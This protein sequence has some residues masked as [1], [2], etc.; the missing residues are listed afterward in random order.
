[1]DGLYPKIDPY[2]H[3][4]LEAGDGNFVYWETCGNPRGKPALVIH[5]GPGSGCTPWHRRLFD[6]AAYRLVLFDQRNCG[7]SQPHASKLGTDLASNRT[8]NLVADVERLREHLHIDRWLVWGGSWGS[9][10]ALVYAEAYAHRVTEIVLWGI[11]T[12]RHREFDWLFRGGVALLFPEEWARLR[13]GVPAATRDA[14]V[15]NAYNG[16]LHDRDP[17]IRDRAALDWCRWE[18]ATLS[19]PPSQELSPRFTDPDFRMAFARI[20]THYVRA[21]AWLADGVVLRDAGRLSG[22]PGVLI[23]ARVDLQAPIGWA[24]DLKRAWP[25]SNLVVVDAAGHDPSVA[26]FT[27]ELI[28]AT[29]QFAA[30]Y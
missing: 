6:C 20:V 24:W 7:R 3:G 17:A 29:D 23:S 22:I 19:W 14:D 21:N 18:S 25:N 28:R 2:E 10:L 5:G 13:A 15:P 26:A 11:T 16:L 27:R 1:M 12:G 30:R 9:T 8:A 4:Q